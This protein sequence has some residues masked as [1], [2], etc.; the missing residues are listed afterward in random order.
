MAI[1]LIHWESNTLVL[2]E[3]V[4]F[5]KPWSIIRLPGPAL[6]HQVKHFFGAHR[7]RRSWGQ[8][9]EA[10]RVEPVLQVLNDLVLSQFWQGLLWAE[11]EHFPDGYTERPHITL[12]WPQSLQKSKQKIKHVLNMLQKGSIISLC[13]LL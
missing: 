12:S 3:L 10:I 8:Q 5:C 9:V 13:I 1:G 11:C 7:S 4:N 6:H 2:Q